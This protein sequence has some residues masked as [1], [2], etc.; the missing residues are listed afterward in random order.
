MFNTSYVLEETLKNT[1]TKTGGWE[2]DV[3]YYLLKGENQKR[4]ADRTGWNLR[5]VHLKY[6]L[7]TCRFGQQACKQDKTWKVKQQCSGIFAKRTGH[8]PMEGSLANISQPFR[9]LGSPRVRPVIGTG[10]V[11]DPEA[12]SFQRT[13]IEKCKMSASALSRAIYAN[14]CVYIIMYHH[15]YTYI[16]ISIFIY[17]YAYTHAYICMYV[18][19]RALP[20]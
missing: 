5:A 13:N 16:Y 8:F 7:Q 19:M 11:W 17:I 18:C 1:L 14:T 20:S 12:A 15:L 6:A 2:E 9:Q 3:F 10:E 4:Q